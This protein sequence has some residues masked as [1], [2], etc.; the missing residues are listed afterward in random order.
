MFINIKELKKINTDL[1]NDNSILKQ[2]K[3][4]LIE[5]NEILEKNYNQLKSQKEQGN[6]EANEEYENKIKE[7][8]AITEK[9]GEENNNLI[10]ENDKLKEEI[11]KK[12]ELLEEYK[13]KDAKIKELEEENKDLKKQNK[14]LKKLK[15][16]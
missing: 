5:K 8:Q 12:E 10:N 4:N 13:L 9:I 3:I 14:Q 11:I 2:E 7:M 1:F 6:N 16:K 15:E